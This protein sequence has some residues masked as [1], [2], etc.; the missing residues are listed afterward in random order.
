MYPNI[1]NRNDIYADFLGL[2]EGK[3]KQAKADANLANAQANTANQQTALIAAQTAAA[4][5]D[6]DTAKATAAKAT[7][8]AQ[9]AIEKAKADAAI[10]E[11]A[12]NKAT[13]TKILG[14]SLPVF[15][16]IV[17]VILVVGFIVYKK[18]IKKA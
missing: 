15:V 4:N 5:A 17:I 11:A 13:E 3:H 2:F 10:A 7:A 8:E 18:F 6:I 9:A 1:Y 14:L 12:L 16:G